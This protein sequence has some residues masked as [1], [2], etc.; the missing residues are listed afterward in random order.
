MTLDQVTR[1]REYCGRAGAILCLLLILAVLDGVTA[2]FRHPLNLFEVFPGSRESVNGPLGTEITG[3]D[4]LKVSSDTDLI[5][6]QV[7]NI[8]TG[9]WFGQKMWRGTIEISPQIKP[10]KYA[11]TV[12]VQGDPAAN[13]LSS[14][15]IRVYRNYED[16]RRDSLSFSIRYLGFSAWDL[17]VGIFPLTCLVFGMVYLLSRREDELL[18]LEGRAEIYR[19]AR[20]D[21]GFEIAFGLGTRH[22]VRVGSEFAL[23]DETG[24]QTT[25]IVAQKVGE[26]DTVAQIGVDSEVKPGYSVRKL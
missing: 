9:F 1:F 6:L 10:G 3:V 20:G 19:I 11:L 5:R 17:L 2:R 18:A 15:A 7:E 16:Y 24:R 8:Q 4:R 13:P 21:W 25:V 22:G 26:T 23:I 14:F 12:S